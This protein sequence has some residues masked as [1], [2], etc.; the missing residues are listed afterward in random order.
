MGH[1]VEAELLSRGMTPVLISEDITSVSP[2]QAKECVCIDFTTPLAF[3][4][5]YLFIAQHF[6][7]A[8]VGTTGWNDIEEEVKQ[9]FLNTHTTLIY[10]SN[11]SLGINALFAAVTKATVLLRDADYQPHI[12]EVHHVHKLDAPSGTAKFIAELVQKGMGV[13]P[14]ISSVREG[15]VPGVHT[16]TLTSDSDILTFRHEAISRKA[17]ARGAVF[18]AQ[19]AETITGV[20]VF[21]EVLEGYF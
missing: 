4:R 17:F 8:V 7:A 3:H 5:N 11:F 1:M 2:M 10:S 19:L 6:K 16:L 15:E 18:A 13:T 9:A 21:S 20:H 14:V 12:E